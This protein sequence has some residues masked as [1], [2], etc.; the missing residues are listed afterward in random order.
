MA[1][2]LDAAFPQGRRQQRQRAR[3]AVDGIHELLDLLAG[4]IAG[5]RC[6]AVSAGGVQHTLDQLHRI[7]AVELVQLPALPL[8]LERRG[9]RLA[10]GEDQARVA[11][12]IQPGAEL[13]DRG[14]FAARLLGERFR[15][16]DE[17]RQ[18][19]ALH[20]VHHQQRGLLGEGSLDGVQGFLQV[21]ERGDRVARHE[22]AADGI[23]DGGG[24]AVRF[25]RDEGGAVH[26]LGAHHPARK[27]GGQRG[28]AFAALAAHHGVAFMPQQPLERQQFPAAPDEAGFR[29]GRQ[30][31]E[32]GGERGLEVR[33][34]LLGGCGFEK[35][36]VVLLLEEH[37]H[38]PIFEA[39]LARA[40]DAAAE[41]VVLELAL[42]G[43]HGVAHAF[44]RR[45]APGRTRRRSAWPS[46][47]ARCGSWPPRRPRRP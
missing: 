2:G 42:A 9:Q 31:A 29:R 11:L 25:D 21:V 15:G 43:E 1:G 26:L 36:R 39:Q 8:R 6:A 10:A 41:G 47:P 40:E 18:Q 33:H 4:G 23:Q 30:S 16:L 32:T 5:G 19:D 14:Q 22:L 24:V 38:E 28:L 7:L 34:R 44:A 35:L 20:V 37:G 27:L 13:E 17:G 3:V 45:R 12:R 46:R